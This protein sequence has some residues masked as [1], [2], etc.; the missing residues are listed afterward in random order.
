MPVK[1]I[2]LVDDSLPWQR[3]V[4]E[5]FESEASQNYCH[6][7]RWIRGNSESQRAT[8][9]RDS[10]GRQPSGAKWLRSDTA[11]SHAFPR[12]E[13]SLLKRTL[14]YRSHRSRLAGRRVGLCLEIKLPFAPSHRHQSHSS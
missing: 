5:M 6:G 9:R 12:F 7:N 3:F 8:A 1:Q 10:D 13:D 14:E 11:D 4:R 2:L